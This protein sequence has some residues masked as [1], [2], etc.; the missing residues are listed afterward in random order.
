MRFKK[1]LITSTVIVLLITST[2]YTQAKSFGFNS[3][4][5]VTNNFI[6]S[7]VNIEIEE[8]FTIEDNW[9]GLFKEKEVAI[10]NLSNTDVL[11]RVNI[12][13]KW[14]DKSGNPVALNASSNI[15]KLKFENLNTD[16]GWI[17]GDD[18]YYYYNSIIK[19]GDSTLPLLSGVELNIADENIAEMYRGNN[20]TID[21]KSECVQASKD[22]YAKTWANINNPTIKSILNNLCIR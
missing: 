21:V 17:Y 6:V 10:K 4:D 13:P 11:L 16:T 8:K 15:V 5:T 2:V 14:E 7:D 20:L 12:T 22:A 19:T 1:I 3:K 18:G 9:S